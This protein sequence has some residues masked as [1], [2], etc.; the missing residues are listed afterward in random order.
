MKD[1][2]V[3]VA[4]CTPEIR[5]ADVDFNVSKIIEQIDLCRDKGVKIAVFPELCITGYTCQDLFFQDIL[6]DK[7]MEGC[8]KIRKS[9]RRTRYAYRR[10]IA[11]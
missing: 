6:L 2:Y 5:V 8:V 4:A 10:R 7:A 11:R 3:K 9:V 1:G